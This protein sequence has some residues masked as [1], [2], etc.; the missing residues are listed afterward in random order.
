MKINRLRTAL[1]A[2]AAFVTLFAGANRA[3]AIDIGIQVGGP[4]PPPHRDYHRWAPPSRG[5]VWIDGHNEW[6]GGQWIWV[7]GYYDYPP[8]PG[9]YWVP[10]RYRHGYWRPGHWSR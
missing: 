7:G 2:G 10:G 3:S 6:R 4:P 5:A 9:A 8:Y 1:L